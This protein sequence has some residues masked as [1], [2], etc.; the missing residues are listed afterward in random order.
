M[1]DSK[2]WRPIEN[3]WNRAFFKRPDGSAREERSVFGEELRNAYRLTQTETSSD[4]DCVRHRIA[5]MRLVSKI[6]AAGHYTDDCEW[7]NIFDD[8]GKDG[9]YKTDVCRCQACRAEASEDPERE[10][11]EKLFAK[12]YRQTVQAT[13][14]LKLG[15]CDT[16]VTN[17]TTGKREYCARCDDITFSLIQM[18]QKCGR[19]VYDGTKL[20]LFFDHHGKG[21]DRCSCFDDVSQD[22]RI[23][24]NAFDEDYDENGWDFESKADFYEHLE[25]AL[26]TYQWTR[27]SETRGCTLACCKTTGGQLVIRRT[28]RYCK[29]AGT[30]EAI[31]RLHTYC[32][33]ASTEN[34]V[35]RLLSSYKDAIANVIDVRND[36]DE[37]DTVKDRAAFT[38]NYRKILALMPSHFDEDTAAA[39]HWTLRKQIHS[40]HQFY[41]RR[42][43]ADAQSLYLKIAHAD[44]AEL[45]GVSD[46]FLE[47]FEGMDPPF[48]EGYMADFRN[49]MTDLGIVQKEIIKGCGIDI[50]EGVEEELEEDV[51]EDVEVDA[52]YSEE[53]D[54]TDFDE[55][56]SED[57]SHDSQSLLNEMA[58]AVAGLS[59][60]QK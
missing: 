4:G 46:S 23:F 32:K 17:C 55:D 35:R 13:Q 6:A 12:Q 20:L 10:M 28:L 29:Y 16:C 40:S 58:E 43:R 56:I 39:Y 22:F 18:L 5:F 44:S 41:K 36:E 52:E 33:D 49:A 42:I 30:E 51:E 57:S 27:P 21:S 14:F 19:A 37:S 50:K 9:D 26:T 1:T 38:E 34:F 53:D 31:K 54:D 24:E 59:V 11:E 45:R 3:S 25:E 60:E 8:Y 47:N 7:L 2:D 48:Y 15:L